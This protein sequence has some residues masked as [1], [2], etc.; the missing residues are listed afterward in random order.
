MT[1]VTEFALFKLCVENPQFLT[2]IDDLNMDKVN[3]P[4]DWM[5]LADEVLLQKK[6][7]KL[8]HMVWSGTTKYFRTMC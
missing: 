3:D 2:D 5:N 4:T 6:A 1:T 7:L 8:F